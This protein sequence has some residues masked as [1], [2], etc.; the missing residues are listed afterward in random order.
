MIARVEWLETALDELANVWLQADSPTRRAISL[1]ARQIERVL[2]ANPEE[3][4]SRT[5]GRRI[6]FS[7]PLAAVFE[8]EPEQELVTLVSVWHFGRRRRSTS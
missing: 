2:S 4:E 6:I 8:F 7:E 1:A 5:G 3:G